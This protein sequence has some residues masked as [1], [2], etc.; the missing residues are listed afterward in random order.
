[1][2]CEQNYLSQQDSTTIKDLFSTEYQVI[3]PEIL[4]MLPLTEDVQYKMVKK[5]FKKFKAKK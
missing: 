4:Y 2:T 5:L 1:M 3:M